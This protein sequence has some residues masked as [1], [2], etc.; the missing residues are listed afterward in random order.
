M[1][2][3]VNLFA[4]MGGKGTKNNNAEL[5]ESIEL[6]ASQLPLLI[7]ANKVQ[8]KYKKSKYDELILQGFTPEQAIELI[9]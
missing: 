4:L 5:K 3:K 9:K 2:D 7:E 6:V 8:A 1:N